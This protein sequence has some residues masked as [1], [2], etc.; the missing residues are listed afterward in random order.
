MIFTE[1]YEGKLEGRK[2]CKGCKQQKPYDLYDK[3]VNS[4]DGYH[5]ICMRCKR[6]FVHAHMLKYLHL[7]A[8]YGSRMATTYTVK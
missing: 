2:L 4:D 8:Q 7:I 1:M 6:K 5:P 3:S